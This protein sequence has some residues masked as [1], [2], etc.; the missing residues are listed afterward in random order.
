MSGASA[1]VPQGSREPRGGRRITVPIALQLALIALVGGLTLTFFG[2]RREAQAVDEALQVY[3]ED[4]VDDA[5]SRIT[6]RMLAYE[7]VLFGTRGLIVSAP[8]VDRAGF[9][10]YV[11]SLRLERI[12]PG[13]QGVGYAVVVP[14]AEF[15]DHEAAI[16][17]EGFPEYAVWPA[18]GRDQYTSIV[19]LEPF[20]GMNLRAFGYDMS[21]EPVRREAMERARDQDV[22]ALSG[23]VTLVQA[24]AGPPQAGTL[25]Y[26]PVYRTGVPHRTVEERRAALVAWVYAPFRMGDLMGGTFGD[27]ATD[28]DV[29]IHDGE[30]PSAG[31]LLFDHDG[32]DHLV[33]GNRPRFS[34]VRRMEIAGRLWVLAVHARPGFGEAVRQ[35]G[36]PRLAVGG[37]VVS[38]LLALLVGFVAT[39]RAQALRIASESKYRSLYRSLRDGY[40]RMSADG[41]IVET[42]D[43]FREMLRCSEEDL[44]GR[45]SDDVTPER[46]H[47]LDRR[48]LTEQVRPR[49]VSEP[50]EKDL[51][52][53]DGTVF[54]VELRIY[55]IREGGRDT[56]TW[57]I[58]TDVS[59]RKRA[60][61]SLRAASS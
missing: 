55:R 7:E 4:R 61:E 5:E 14:V 31:T 35:N 1:S 32:E 60:E 24:G 25:L 36:P 40:V 30:A 11:A 13:I 28:V 9:R 2:W 47:D 10:R 16:R 51:R 12:Y 27:V 29:E 6:A 56:G 22:P 38:V 53:C 23:R 34:T 17:G 3:F 37:T 26:L 19:F 41:S 59:D 52:R 20:T 46:W 21:S 43:A 57:A 8:A 42:N 33:G 18:G 48:V 58:V 39:T 49:G 15:H 54:P 50:Y 45:T 44:R